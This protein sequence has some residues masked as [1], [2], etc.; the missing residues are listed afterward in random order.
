MIAI[1]KDIAAQCD[2]VRCDMAMLVTNEIFAQT[3]GERAGPSPAEEY[4]VEVIRAVS[5]SSPN[6]V[7]I[8]EA[9]W[10]MEWALQQLGFAYCYDKRLY[11]RLLR[12][13]AAAVAGHLHA[14]PGYQSGLVRFIENHDERRAAV[15][16]SPHQQRAAAVTVATQLGMRLFHEGQLDGHR[17]RLPVFLGRRPVEQPNLEV[18]SFYRSLL[19]TL[20]AEPLRTGTWQL[21]A[22]DGWL[23][24]ES[25]HGLVAWAWRQGERWALVVVNLSDGSAQGL[26]RLGWE[27]LAGRAWR[28]GDALSESIYD[29]DGDELAAAGLYVDLPPWGCHLLIAEP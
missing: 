19:A 25:F 29:R 14:D 7:W 20:R 26:V 23:S 11:D 12:G 22:I 9:Y 3:W 1:L 28:L 13:G 18:L 4:W 15:A 27:G 17:T 21:C 8:A 24:S 10:D 2:G 16:F 5:Q 6:F